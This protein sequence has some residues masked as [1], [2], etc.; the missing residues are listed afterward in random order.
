MQHVVTEIAVLLG[1]IPVVTIL[2]FPLVTPVAE[3]TTVIRETHVVT[4]VAVLQDI[5]SVEAA[6][7]MF[8]DLLIKSLDLS[9]YIFATQFNP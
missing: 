9:I 3:A 8:H 6:L 1:T 5:L 2:V 4:E 7:A